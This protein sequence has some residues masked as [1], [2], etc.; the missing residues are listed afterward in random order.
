MGVG[1]VLVKVVLLVVVVL[2]L[3]AVLLLVIWWWWCNADRVPLMLLL[4]WFMHACRE[5]TKVRPACVVRPK[6]D[7]S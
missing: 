4:F 6:R 2:L 1:V 5:G 7:Q 3:L